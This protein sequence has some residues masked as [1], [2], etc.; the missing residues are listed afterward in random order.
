MEFTNN[1][2]DDLPADFKP[3][4]KIYSMPTFE[5]IMKIQMNKKIIQIEYRDDC[6]DDFFKFVT[7]ARIKRIEKSLE[8]VILIVDSKK[9]IENMPE[10]NIIYK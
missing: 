10:S 3:N 7:K 4:C 9:E 5:T 6:K 1:N 2:L 8:K